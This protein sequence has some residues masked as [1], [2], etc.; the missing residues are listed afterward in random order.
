MLEAG[1]SGPDPADHPIGI[2]RLKRCAAPIRAL[3]AHQRQASLV[4]SRL[5]PLLR[6]TQGGSCDTEHGHDAAELRLRAGSGFSVNLRKVRPDGT[7]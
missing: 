5:D 1:A 4:K 7:G 2:G 3:L 6:A